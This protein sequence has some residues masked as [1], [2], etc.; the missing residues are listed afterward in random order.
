MTQSDTEASELKKMIADYMENGFLENIIDMFK[1]DKDLYELIGNLLIDE[2]IM[3]RIGTVALVETLKEE[4]P[5]NISRAIPYVLPVLKNENPV[6]RGDAAY[7]LGIIGNPD[8]IPFL[9]EMA[10]DEDFDVK[11]IVKE[12]I[13][14]IES[15][16]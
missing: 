1:H 7:V 11:Q 14:E 15:K 5:E 3:V 8:A 2:R 4:D 13:D 10:D 6:Y 12:A 9:G 16:S